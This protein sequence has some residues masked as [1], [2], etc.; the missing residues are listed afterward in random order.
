MPSIFT[1]EEW[2]KQKAAY[3]A[4]NRWEEE[5]RDFPDLHVAT[6]WWWEM[7][8]LYRR[9]HPDDPSLDPEKYE[10]LAQVRRALSFL[11]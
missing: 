5:Q 2:Q 4:F 7:L 1:A 3:E 8:C 6:T 11:R 10:H 9:L